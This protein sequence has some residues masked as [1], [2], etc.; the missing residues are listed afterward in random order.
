MLSAED[1]NAFLQNLAVSISKQF[2]RNCEVAIH[3][4]QGDELI[5]K[6]IENGYI[7]GR[8][9]GDVSTNALLEEFIENDFVRN[10]VYRMTT[11]SGREILSS[12]TPVQ[13]GGVTTGYVCINYDV[14]D[15]IGVGRALEWA[16]DMHRPSEMVDIN[17]VLKYHLEACCQLI[18]KKPEDMDRADKFRAVEY[19]ES[20]HVFLITKS[21]IKV[22]EYLNLTKYALYTFLDEIRN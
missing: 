16:V 20:K 21:S 17:E 1:T 11:K 19:L 15:L 13:E 2:G 8:H 5:I 3:E 9:P 7:T 4:F 18:G 12:T 6:H 22:C 10:P 14:T